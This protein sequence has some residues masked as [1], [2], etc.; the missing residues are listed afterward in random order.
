M[1]LPAF[2]RIGAKRHA[3]RSI[4]RINGLESHRNA[5]RFSA[6][7]YVGFATSELSGFVSMKPGDRMTF[8]AMPDGTVVMRLKSRTIADAAGMLHK[9]GRKAVPVEQLSR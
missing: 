8:T 4:L 5:G 6:E 7:V 3:R 2:S 9:K 1:F